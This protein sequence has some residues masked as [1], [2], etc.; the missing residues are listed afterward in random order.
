MNLAI[1]EDVLETARKLGPLIRKDADEAE[2]QRR[3]SGP[4]VDTL[5]G[6][7]MFRLFLPRSLGGLEADPVTAARVIEE[8]STFDSA[9]GW[10]VM[11][12]SNAFFACRL[13]KEGMEEIYGGSDPRNFAAASF[14]PPMTAAAVDGGY[15]LNRPRSPGEPGGGGFLAARDGGGQGR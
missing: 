11:L 12:N 6:A 5:V 7:G 3:L 15:M 10:A 2:R 4:V 9:A 14:N 13:P 1:D 8:I